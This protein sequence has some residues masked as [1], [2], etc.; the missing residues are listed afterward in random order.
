M[1]EK[2]LAARA[3]ALDLLS[4]VLEDGRQFGALLEDKSGPLRRL[5]GPGRARAQR[6]AADTLRGLGAADAHLKPL[7]NR[8]PPLRVMNILRMAVVECAVA[9]APEHGAVDASV[10]LVRKSRQ[11]ARFSGLT[12]AVLRKAV[13]DVAERWPDLPPSRLPNWLRGRLDAAY[14][15]P[16]VAA[17]ERSHTR[18]PPVDLTPRDGDAQKL[19]QQVNGQVLPTGSVRLSAGVQ[20]SALPGFEQGDWWV[21]DAAAAVA[22]RLIQAGPGQNVLDLCAAPGGK[23]LQLAATGAAVT[24]VD[25][26]AQRLKRLD[27]NLART[28]LRAH[29]VTADALEWQPNEL[30]DA[31]LLDAPCTATG[32][33]R[34]HP[35]LPYVQSADALRQLT[36]LQSDLIDR[37][38]HLVKPGGQLLFSTCSLLPA[39]GED[40]IQ[41]ALERHPD[42]RVLTPEGTTGTNSDWWG[43]HGLRLRPD[44]WQPMGGMDGFFICLLERRQT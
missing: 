40:Q 23:T 16:I 38:S 14:G 44:Y 20:I 26:S 7:L 3:A 12:N 2:S 22:A 13:A 6:L 11:T 36:T 5:D 34:R 31:V 1:A 17:I 15:R 4:G 25:I 21:Q 28:R 35:D 32:T 39:E 8:K 33:I 42:F 19:A 29:V 27:E 41:A 18:R 43:P 9:G 37:A 10:T 30:F 24:A